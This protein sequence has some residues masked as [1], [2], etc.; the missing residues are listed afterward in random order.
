MFD[1]LQKVFLSAFG[2]VTLE[3]QKGPDFFV[4]NLL[5]SLY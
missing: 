2:G 1:L 4:N 3:V 5:V